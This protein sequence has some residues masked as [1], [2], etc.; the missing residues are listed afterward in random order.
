MK[1][2]VFDVLYQ[3]FEPR[4]QLPLSEPPLMSFNIPEFA[5]EPPQVSERDLFDHVGIEQPP[6]WVKERK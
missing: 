2:V 5:V 6:T 3:A 1:F 4:L